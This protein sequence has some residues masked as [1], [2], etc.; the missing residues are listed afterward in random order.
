MGGEKLSYVLKKIK[1]CK[2]NTTIC[3]ETAFYI[4]ILPTRPVKTLVTSLQSIPKFSEKEDPLQKDQ[5]N[6]SGFGFWPNFT[7]GAG[8][9]NNYRFKSP[10]E[11]MLNKKKCMK[12]MDKDVQLGAKEEE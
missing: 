5:G 12:V 11:Y 2:A 8:I 6:D 7:F 4:L 9:D 3:Y 10:L 1:F